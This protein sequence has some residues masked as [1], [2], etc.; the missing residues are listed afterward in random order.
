M[1]QYAETGIGRVL[2][3]AP[4]NRVVT[5]G[6]G[7]VVTLD[8]STT[9]RAWLSCTLSAAGLQGPGEVAPGEILTL[10]G[11][12][13]GPRGGAAFR[14]VNGGV[15]RELEGTRVLFDGQPAPVLY[16]QNGQVNAIA[17]Y[18]LIPGATVTIEVEY[19]GMRLG[20]PL[21]V[22]NAR[23]RIFT[24]DGSGSGY[25]AALNQDG[26]INSP[27]NPAQPGSVISLFL[28]GTGL[29]ATPLREGEVATTIGTA[30]LANFRFL[31]TVGTTAGVFLVTDYAG[32]AP[33]LINSVTQVT[34][35]CPPRSL[36]STP[37][38]H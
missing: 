25:A 29:A 35:A 12:G 22:A 13:L 9:P 30:P 33:G 19:N 36:L 15:P 21:T 18:S 31:T 38:R 27:Q 16:A 11:A 3:F 26:S 10:V 6:A 34:F 7:G 14:L 20:T 5:A 8:L 23:P 4:D 2:R 32:L 24:V 28:T 17:P 37:S 1:L